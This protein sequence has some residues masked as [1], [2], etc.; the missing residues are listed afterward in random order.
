[1]VSYPF[2]SAVTE[3]LHMADGDA[4][5]AIAEYVAGA[6]PTVLEKMDRHL[7]ET[8]VNEYKNEQRNRLVVLYACF[9]YLEA[10]KTGRFS[11]RW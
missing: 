11:A 3:W 5:D 4:L 10:Q 8:T 2:V 9:K 6:T 1:M 7:R